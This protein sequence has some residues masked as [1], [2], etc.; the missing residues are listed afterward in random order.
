M[1]AVFPREPLC[2][3][4]ARPSRRRPG[5]TK[6]YRVG[7][8]MSFGDIKYLRVLP[9]SKRRTVSESTWL[10]CRPT[11]HIPSVSSRNANDIR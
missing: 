3:E 7:T 2:R 1:R 10:D 9:A 8:A 6:N 5:G 4:R 11:G